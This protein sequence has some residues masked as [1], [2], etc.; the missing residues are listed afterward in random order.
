V[1]PPRFSLI[2]VSPALIE[3]GA[4][5]A[6]SAVARVIIGYLMTERIPPC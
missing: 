3:I 5:P 2:E 4:K 1:C 6:E